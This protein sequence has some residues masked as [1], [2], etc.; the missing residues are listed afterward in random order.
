LIATIWS[1]DRLLPSGVVTGRAD[2]WAAFNPFESDGPAYEGLIG[3]VIRSGS[4]AV[5]SKVTTEEP[6]SHHHTL[7]RFRH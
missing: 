1:L 2:A 3:P 4:S 5:P 7:A 6:P